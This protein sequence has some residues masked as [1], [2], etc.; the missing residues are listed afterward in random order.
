MTN[1]LVVFQ[2]ILYIENLLYHNKPSILQTNFLCP[3]WH[4]VKLKIHCT[5]DFYIIKFNSFKLITF[6]YFVYF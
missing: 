4:F 5:K 6:N 3:S 1:N 2:Q